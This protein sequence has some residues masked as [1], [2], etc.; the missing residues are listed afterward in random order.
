MKVAI[1]T[2]EAY[3]G[4]TTL[5]EDEMKLLWSVLRLY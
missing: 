2:N 3:K 4:G 5:E 1:L